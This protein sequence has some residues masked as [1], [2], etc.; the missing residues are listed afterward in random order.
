M[1]ARRS[2]ASGR[3]HFC[4]FAATSLS[5]GSDRILAGPINRSRD[6]IAA[7]LTTLHNHDWFGAGAYLDVVRALN[8]NGLKRSTKRLAEK[9]F[10]TKDY[11]SFLFRP[12]ITD[13]AIRAARAIPK[14]DARGYFYFN[15]E[16]MG[17]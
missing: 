9:K 6:A 17:L 2:L 5:I 4:L 12:E 15:A 11:Q 8:E 14:P 3:R 13:G 7:A 1:A 10:G 16:D